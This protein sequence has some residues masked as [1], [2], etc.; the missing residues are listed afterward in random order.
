MSLPKI[1]LVVIG[2]KDHGKSTLIGRL[3]YDSKAIPEQKLREIKTEIESTT[4]KE[5]EFAYIL[6]SLE[7]ERI[8]GLTID[9]TQ[10]PF[11]SKRYQYT[12]IDA[13][14]HREFIKKMLT[15]ASQAD[16]AV[17]VLSAKE[18]IED[19]T[20]QH[21]F[22]AKTLGINQFVIAL[23]KMD[24]F[25]YDEGTYRKRSEEIQGI[26]DTM[27]FPG[28]PIVPISALQ[29]D[30]ITEKSRHMDWY[31]GDTLI[32]ALDKAVSPASQPTE[33]PLR[34][35]VQD[36]YTMPREKIIVC[37]IEAG[38]IEVGKNVIS[39]PSGGRG[40]VTKIESYGEERK[41][42]A[43]GDSVGLVIRGIGDIKRGE[44]ISGPDDPAA[45][46][47]KFTAELII[48]SDIQIKNGDVLEIKA[49][50]S[51][52]KH[53]V[54]KMLEKIDPINLVIEETNPVVLKNGEVG[55]VILKPTYPVCLELYSEFPPLGRFVIL[56]E[57]GTAAAGIIL[58]IDR[59]G[60][61]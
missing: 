16:A 37:K 41:E 4:K 30:N 59:E 18:G 52:G 1:S 27:G 6:D 5:F 60:V 22:L 24:V 31:N 23:N 28:S 20:K 58:G 43:P 46:T 17:L 32:D 7:E 55:K 54:E 3:L 13:P 33:K 47:K 8:G 38:K 40:V 61:R 19:Q 48:F 21:L 50:T 44:V 29:G 51:E 39:L 11:K 9:I 56:N 42:A 34:A 57:K 14:G 10:M 53:R 26:L 15:G 49:G 45:I 12:I 35:T 36:V 2:H 25:S